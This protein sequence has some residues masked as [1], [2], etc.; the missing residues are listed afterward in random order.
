MTSIWLHTFAHHYLVRT[1]T[2]KVAVTHHLATTVKLQ[3]E[4][5][6]HTN[7]A[8][9]EVELCCLESFPSRLSPLDV[10]ILKSKRN[11]VFQ[12]GTDTPSVLFTPQQHQARYRTGILLR[13]HPATEVEISKCSGGGNYPNSE[14][15]HRVRLF[16]S[17]YFHRHH[18]F[19]RL[20]TTGTVRYL[21]PVNLDRVVLGARSR[22]S[23]RWAG[24]E[25]FNSGLL[26]LCRSGQEVLARQGD[27]LLLPQHPLFGENQR[28]VRLR[29]RLIVRGTFENLQTKSLTNFTKI[30]VNVYYIRY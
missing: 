12:H 17:T 29:K 3:E 1:P 7:M 2:W 20:K 11:S 24:T 23:L 18:R 16:T 27:P 8:A 9:V 19:Q 15:N 22:Q 25:Q 30:F 26:D 5:I 6:D 4:E 10:L 21:E 14:S 28:Q 13:V